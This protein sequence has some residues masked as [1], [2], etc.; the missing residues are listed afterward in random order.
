M[1][2]AG[3]AVQVC[4]VEE[5]DFKLP[6]NAGRKSRP[7]VEEIESEDEEENYDT[8]DPSDGARCER[9]D[10][11]VTRTQAGKKRLHPPPNESD[12]HDPTAPSPS[13]RKTA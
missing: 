7:P 12:S 4:R 9:S 2:R 10:S 3:V 13:R 1:V 5:E 6:K 8:L 11:P